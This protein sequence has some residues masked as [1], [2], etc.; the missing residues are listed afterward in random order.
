MRKILIDPNKGTFILI[1]DTPKIEWQG[2]II[3]H[4]FTT[5]GKLLSSFEAIKNY[6]I[7]TKGWLDIGYHYII[8]YVNNV[9]TIRAGRDLDTIGAHTIGKNETH[10][11]IC[12][13]GNF[14]ETKPD[15][16]HYTLTAQLCSALISGYKN[17]TVDNIKP[18]SLYAPYKTCC[19]HLFDFGK[20]VLEI[21]RL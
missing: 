19:G 14:D 6:H 15:K 21:E 16:D 11:G 18:H 2:I 12:I 8:E 13:V 10:L 5:D 7:K 4:S 17:L 20:L 3:H 1:P 9:L